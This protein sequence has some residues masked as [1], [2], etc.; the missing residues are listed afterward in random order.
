MTMLE[1]SLKSRWL[2]DQIGV[3]DL[4]EL[5]AESTSVTEK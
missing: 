3:R 4:A 1:E 2:E 5:I